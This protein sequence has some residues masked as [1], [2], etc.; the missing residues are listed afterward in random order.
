M[1]WYAFYLNDI[2]WG[3]R[4]EQGIDLPDIQLIIQWRASCD[5]CTLWQRFGR[6]V[7]DLK[8]QGRALFLVEPKY[9]DAAKR[10][11]AD[12]ELKRKAAERE[13]GKAPPRKRSR[14]SKGACDSSKE[15]G[16]ATNA[17]DVVD[18]PLAAD[19]ETASNTQ[20]GPSN[21]TSSIV[22]SAPQLDDAA[23]Q[24]L[25]AEQ[26]AEYE[27][28]PKVERKRGVRKVEDIEPALDDMVNAKDHPVRCSRW[29]AAVYFRQNKDGS[30]L[31]CRH[32]F[33]YSHTSLDAC[34]YRLR[35][36]CLHA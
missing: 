17:D 34:A 31:V 27:K 4:S 9:F 28:I 32:L 6:A 11:K 26:R 13:A 36:P 15:V 1:E 20:S 29:A 10:A 30:L 18:R 16:E 12:A 23:R 22:S 19:T 8:L 24:L 14:T 33:I 7:R 5:L 2:V 25:E 21:A 35:S 3:L